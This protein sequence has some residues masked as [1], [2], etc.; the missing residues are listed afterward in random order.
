MLAIIDPDV[1]G[2]KIFWHAI[3]YYGRKGKRLQL[4]RCWKVWMGGKGTTEDDSHLQLT[5]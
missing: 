2:W 4:K 5:K 1:S 3:A